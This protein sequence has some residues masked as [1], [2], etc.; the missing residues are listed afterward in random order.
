MQGLVRLILIGER[1][2]ARC[3]RSLPG[4]PDPFRAAAPRS[5]PTAVS[6]D[7]L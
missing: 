7:G 5:L 6:S 1:R 4:G 3:D 2:P